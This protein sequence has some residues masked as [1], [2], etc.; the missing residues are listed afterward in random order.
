M[1]E[2]SI[3]DPFGTAGRILAK[4][5]DFDLSFEP[6]IL[7]FLKRE[8]ASPGEIWRNHPRLARSI[9]YGSGVGHLFGGAVVQLIKMQNM[10]NT[11][12][13]ELQLEKGRTHVGLGFVDLQQLM[14]AELISK[15][16]DGPVS[17]FGFDMNPIAVA[18]TKLVLAMLDEEVPIV[19]ILQL[20]F[21]TVITSAETLVVF[22]KR[23]MLLE[24]DRELLHILR[25]WRENATLKSKRDRVEYARYILTGEIFLQGARKTTGNPTFFPPP[26]EPFYQRCEE[27]IFHSV[28]INNFD[29]KDSLLTSIE[30]RFQD[31]LLKLKKNIKEGLIGVTVST[32]SISPSNKDPGQDQETRACY[33]RLVKPP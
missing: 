27:N 8:K 25:C 33:D 29:Y 7:D 5:W 1:Q 23:L 18:K 20:W 22:S 15:A 12:S 11:P 30:K 28:D 16:G 19:Q 10:R 9:P 14:E 13:P 32:A 26:D 3:L 31:N 21:S 2:E 24:K 6:G 17:W 4:R